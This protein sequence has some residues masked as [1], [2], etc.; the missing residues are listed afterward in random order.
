M[1]KKAEPL[2]KW[3]LVS[4]Q[5]CQCLSVIVQNQAVLFNFTSL[6]SV[7]DRSQVLVTERKLVKRRKI[8]LD[9]INNVTVEQRKKKNKIK[10]GT[11]RQ[12]AWDFQK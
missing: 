12:A 2:D 11:C 8:V 4:K 1:A 7:P 9:K 6:F 5:W 3:F 10:K